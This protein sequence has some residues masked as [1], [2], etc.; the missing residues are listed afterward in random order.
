MNIKIMEEQKLPEIQTRTIELSKPDKTITLKNQS[1]GIAHIIYEP[2]YY[3]PEQFFFKQGN[4]N[5]PDQPHRLICCQ[6]NLVRV[7]SISADQGIQLESQHQIPDFIEKGKEQ[8]IDQPKREFDYAAHT[9][10]L[11][12]SDTI[13]KSGSSPGHANFLQLD[14]N[15]QHNESF[16]L[17]QSK[18]VIFDGDVFNRDKFET[19]L[20]NSARIYVRN[21][22]FEIRSMEITESYL[23]SQKMKTKP[24]IR[25]D[26]DNKNLKNLFFSALEKIS[27]SNKRLYKRIFECTDWEDSSESWSDLVKGRNSATIKDLNKRLYSVRYDLLDFM[28]VFK[29]YDK[30]SGKVLKST[31]LVHGEVFRAGLEAKGIKGDLNPSLKARLCEYDFLEDELTFQALFVKRQSTHSKT[32]RIVLKAKNHLLAKKDSNR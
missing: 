4:Q 18:P 16:Q 9:N 32:S 10:Q 26:R 20:T 8:K 27:R 22:I 19:N 23:T 11:I 31:T 24:K 14:L 7:F 5:S 1:L 21:S 15:K 6:R 17:L 13:Q 29:I 12:I 28:S 30:L 25:F 3:N 2:D